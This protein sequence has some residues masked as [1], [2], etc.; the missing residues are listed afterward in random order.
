MSDSEMRVFD[1][2][3][4]KYELAIVAAR[5]ARRINSILRFSGEELTEKVTMRALRKALNSEVKYHYEE[6][7]KEQL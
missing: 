3:S 2:V 5:E 7:P 6:T 4:N 1:Q